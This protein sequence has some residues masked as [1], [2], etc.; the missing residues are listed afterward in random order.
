MNTT[1]FWKGVIGVGY[2][3]A[4]IYY[5]VDARAWDASDGRITPD[6]DYGAGSAADRYMERN[7]SHYDPPVEPE[8]F[9]FGEAYG[10]NDL[11]TRELYDAYQGHRR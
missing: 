3:V 8:T 4:A 9:G 5:S 7:R 10:G 1:Q 2:V 11:Y 6:R